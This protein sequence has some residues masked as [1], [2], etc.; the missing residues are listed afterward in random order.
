M[1]AVTLTAICHQA[2]VRAADL[3]PGFVFRQK[4][5]TA[6]QCNAE[7]KNAPKGLHGAQYSA[8]LKVSQREK[9]KPGVW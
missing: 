1:S 9:L 5:A 4:K 2:K 7:D 8:T 3:N 6:K